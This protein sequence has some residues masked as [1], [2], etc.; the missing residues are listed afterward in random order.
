M[1][2]GE[3]YSVRFEAKQASPSNV[4]ISRLYV[5]GQFDQIQH[6]HQQPSPRTRSF[7]CNH[8]R[9]KV[10]FF[11]F[12]KISPVDKKKDD[13]VFKV[14]FPVN[15]K[16]KPPIKQPP[17]QQ[18]QQQQPQP[19]QQ[20]PP[21]PQTQPQSPPSQPQQ[22]PPQS[23]PQPQPQ[24]QPQQQPPQSQ[25]QPQQQQS[26]PQPP[27]PQQQ[28]QQQPQPQPQPQQPQKQQSVYGKPG[29]ITVC[30]FKGIIVD[31]DALQDKP[32]FEVKQVKIPETTDNKNKGISY[33]TGFDA[34]HAKIQPAIVTKIVNLNPIAVL[35]LHYRSEDWFAD[36]EISLPIL[37]FDKEKEKVVEILNA[38][39]NEG[40]KKHDEI[41]KEPKEPQE[42]L[43][44]E[45]KNSVEQKPVENEAIILQQNGL[46]RNHDE[47]NVNDKK[48]CN[49]SVLKKLCLDE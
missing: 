42:I 4:I 21:Q 24:Q 31:Q 1:T 35:H 6:L 14:P 28:P 20:Q 49:N 12:S 3:R 39:A 36:K 46:K 11:K 17:P 27:Q 19:S 40:E 29:S 38:N 48:E 5:D 7:F 18:P 22:Q 45:N 30:F 26:Q 44:T 41:A 13:N 37:N 8:E 10:Y 9:T 43:E 25:P 2:P 15:K 34:M 33:T 16:N 23:Q 47:M 32:E